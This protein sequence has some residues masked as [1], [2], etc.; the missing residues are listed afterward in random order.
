MELQRLCPGI[1][2]HTQDRMRK[3]EI[4]MKKTIAILLVTLLIGTLILPISA[5]AHEMAWWVSGTPGNYTL[6]DI[7]LK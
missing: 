3:S 5:N 2:K 6:S 7:V 1:M 4:T